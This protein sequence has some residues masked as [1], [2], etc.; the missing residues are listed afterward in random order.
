MTGLDFRRRATHL[1]EL[2]DDPHA[3]PALLRDTYARFGRMNDLLSGWAHLYRAHLRPHLHPARPNTLLDIG[4]GG[5]DVARNLARWAARDGL[6]LRVTGIDTDE[7]AIAYARA[8]PAHSGLHFR[9]ASSGDLV[10]GAEAYDLVVSNHLLHHLSDPA[11]LALLRDCEALARVQVVHNDIERHPL[12]YA[13]FAAFVAPLFPHSM[14]PVDGRRS[15]RRSFTRAELA[16]LAPAGWQVRRQVPFRLWL[17]HG[18]R[19]A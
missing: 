16:A 1:P 12:A 7:R 14:I 18:V 3:D 10:R 4:C 17:T 2:M 13:A 19:R 5:G 6:T 9:V 15:V 11:L 8:Q